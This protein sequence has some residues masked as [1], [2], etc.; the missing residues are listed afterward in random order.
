MSEA[1]E[2]VDVL[3]RYVSLLFTCST[4][5]SSG[6]QAPSSLLLLLLVQGVAADV[7]PLLFARFAPQLAALLEPEGPLLERVEAGTGDD[8]EDAASRKHFLQLLLLLRDALARIEE[9][10][11]QPS[12][13]VP[14]DWKATDVVAQL[15]HLA[16]TKPGQYR[17]P[18]ASWAAALQLFP[19]ASPASPSSSSSLLPLLGVACQLAASML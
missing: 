15:R 9:A 16:A 13:S 1:A 12:Q 7:L 10:T 18:L 19:S 8:E 6:P 5:P 17:A 2:R 3:L 4:P 11:E 14:G